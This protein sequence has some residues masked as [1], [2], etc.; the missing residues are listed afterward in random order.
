MASVMQA[1]DDFALILSEAMP[2]QRS[3]IFSAFCF[4]V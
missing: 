4:A 1:F 2:D 3:A